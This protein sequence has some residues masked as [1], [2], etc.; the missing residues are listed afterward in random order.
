M[1]SFVAIKLRVK[2][3]KVINLQATAKGISKS[4]AIHTETRII[5][6]VPYRYIFPP[7]GQ[8]GASTSATLTG[9]GFFAK[10][11]FLY[12]WLCVVKFFA[13]ASI[14]R[15]LFADHQ[16]VYCFSPIRLPLFFFVV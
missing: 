11:H 10:A 1:S 4:L 12:G 7:I 13:E 2:S 3:Q 5:R 16:Q 15:H 6:E 9:S 14:I 8:G